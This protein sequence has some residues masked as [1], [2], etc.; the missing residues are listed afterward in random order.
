MTESIP[1]SW[2]IS[3]TTDGTSWN[4]RGFHAFT[5]AQRLA[6]CLVE[7]NDGNPAFFIYAERMMTVNLTSFLDA[8][9]AGS[10][11]LAPHMLSTAKTFA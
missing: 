8:T 3:W 11:E 7:E 2:K 10:V 4:E 6:R 5:T 1:F 9:C